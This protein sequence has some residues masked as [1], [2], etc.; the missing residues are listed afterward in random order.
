M[1]IIRLTSFLVKI[2]RSIP[3]IREFIQ[4]RVQLSQYLEPQLQV[5]QALYTL[6]ST[7]LF[8]LELKSNPRYSDSKRLLHFGFQVCAQHREDGMIAEI[9]SRIGIRDRIFLE[10]GIGDGIENNTSFLASQG[11]RGFW[12]DAD[13][14]FIQELNKKSEIAT[15]IR[16]KVAKITR[17]NIEGLLKE[18][19]VPKE[20]DLLSLDIDQNTYYAWEGMGNFRPRVI[21]IEYNAS[22]PPDIDW[23]V[24]YDPT[25][26]W[27]RSANYGASLKALELLGRDRGYSLIGCDFSGTNAF[28][29][30]DDVMDVGMFSA[31]FTAE[32]HYEPPRYPFAFAA[33]HP[34]SIMDS[35]SRNTTDQSLT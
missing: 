20:F 13:N 18:L 30:R 24:K 25:R 33:G 15:R 10:I 3:I 23:K 12:I 31:P 27:D 32:N 1:K 14:T 29:V 26:V 28:F 22:L 9:F 16:W 21:V 6:Q 34:R 4:I 7:R 11:W 5:L 2:Y 35:S 8:D 19:Q 17:E